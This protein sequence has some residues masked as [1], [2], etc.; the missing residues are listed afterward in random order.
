MVHT[1]NINSFHK[2]LKEFMCDRFIIVYI[3]RELGFLKC[4]LL[5][6]KEIS[7]IKATDVTK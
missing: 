7:V 5:A 3:L 1:K 4:K 6:F 2:R